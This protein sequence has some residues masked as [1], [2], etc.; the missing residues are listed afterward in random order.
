MASGAGRRFQGEKDAAPR[1]KLLADFLGRPLITAVLQTALAVPAEARIAVTRAP[2]VK[3]LCDGFDFPCLLHDQPQLNDTIRLGLS[4]LS[5]F[6][7][8]GCLFLQGDQPL[9]TPDSI[10]ALMHAFRR[11]QRFIYR[12][13]FGETAGSPVLFPKA[14]F[15]ELLCLPADCGGSYIIK[16]YPQLVR[17]VEAHYF[18][19]L[20]DADTPAELER[21]RTLAR[22]G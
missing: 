7:I 5:S 19:E 6:Q 10:K 18:W 21:L 3:Q 11:D 8:D 16:K 20:L 4:A 1:N 14:L 2:Q 9:L 17:T 15:P 12:L 22:R 13:S